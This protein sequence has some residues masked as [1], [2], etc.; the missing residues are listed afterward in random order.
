MTIVGS[1]N[2]RAESCTE[3]LRGAYMTCKLRSILRG[4]T[5]AGAIF[6]LGFGS[7]VHAAETACP[8]PGQTRVLQVQMF[9]GMDIG[10][11]GRVV[12]AREWK[13][14]VEGDATPLFPAGFSVW[15]GAGQWLDP[16]TKAITREKSKIM[17]INAPD[18]ADFR[19]KVGE[20]SRIYREKFRQ[21]AVGITTTESCA[22]F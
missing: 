17:M 18:T 2:N 1:V 11:N 16:E 15:D 9:F 8:F 5:F 4:C 12:T 19:Q 6:G 10:V 22:A 20:L 7:I 3:D 13:S 21:K 14:F